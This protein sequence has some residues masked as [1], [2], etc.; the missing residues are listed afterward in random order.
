MGGGL[1]GI[2]GYQG[3]LGGLKL[4]ALIVSEEVG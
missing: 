2:R 4:V 1:G 3:E